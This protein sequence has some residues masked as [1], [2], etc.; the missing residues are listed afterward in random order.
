MAL[1]KERKEELVAKYESWLQESEA[2]FLTE[3]SGLDMPAI[4]DLRSRIREAGGEFHIIKNRLG[5]LAFKAAGY[6]VPEDYLLGSTAIGVAFEDPPAV[7]KALAEFG[8]DNEAIKI[9]GGYLAGDHLVLEQVVR[10]ATL[11]PLPAVRAQLLA[12]I[13]TPATQLARLVA[14]PSRQIAQVIKAY[15]DQGAAAA[16]EAEAAAEEPAAEAE[17]ATEEAA[18]EAKEAKAEADSPAEEEAAAETEEPAE[19]ESPTEEEAD[20]EEAP[21][22][23]ADQDTG[24]APEGESAD[25]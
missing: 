23:E 1:S 22:D 25:N 16:G 2:V 9:K 5:K 10:L 3:Y 7:A 4:D 14:E 18:A 20:A 15:G 13:L 6:E 8:E 11:P 12:L 17:A 24:D 21:A 19:A